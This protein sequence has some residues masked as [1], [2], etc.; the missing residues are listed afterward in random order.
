MLPSW[1]SAGSGGD[2]AG[3]PEYVHIRSPM[4]ISP[5]RMGLKSQPTTRTRSG[6]M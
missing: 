3:K 1:E 6:A 4:M 5:C 2:D